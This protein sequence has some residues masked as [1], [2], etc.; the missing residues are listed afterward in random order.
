MATLTLK[1]PDCDGCD[2]MSLASLAREAEK[3]GTTVERM[4]NV[5]LATYFGF[6]PPEDEDE[7]GWRLLAEAQGWPRPSPEVAAEN[8]HRILQ[9]PGGDGDD[10]DKD[11]APS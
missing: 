5:I 11:V 4:M 1:L 2:G 10:D 3:R 9:E 6:K 7:R 8:L